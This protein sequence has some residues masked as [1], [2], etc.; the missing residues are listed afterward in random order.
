M[1]EVVAEMVDMKTLDV[2]REMIDARELIC[3]GDI[4]GM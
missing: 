2:M 1:L 4:F 3:V